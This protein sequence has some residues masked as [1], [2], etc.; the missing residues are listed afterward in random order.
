[1]EAT[2]DRKADEAAA[3]VR[4]HYDRLIQEFLN[5]PAISAGADREPQHHRFD[6][7]TNTEPNG[8]PRKPARAGSKSGTE[9][10]TAKSFAGAGRAV[11]HLNVRKLIREAAL[12]QTK[13]FDITHIREYLDARYPAESL[14]IT[15]NRISKDLS[16]FRTDEGI[17]EIAAPPPKKG[18]MNLYQ[19][20]V[21]A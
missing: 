21:A 9:T 6:P 7:K 14:L 13:P 1:M 5:G 19:N 18:G 11:R 15:D 10:G 2:R 12:A 3:A 16:Y 20:K 17:L 8:Q 4:A